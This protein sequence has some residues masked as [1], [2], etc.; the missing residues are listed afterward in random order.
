[1]RSGTRVSVW[2]DRV[3]SDV[4]TCRGVRGKF[5]AGDFPENPRC[6]LSFVGAGDLSPRRR[7]PPADM[8]SWTASARCALVA[9]A[10]TARGRLGAE[11]RLIHP[12]RRSSADVR[13]RN[14]SG[15]IVGTGTRKRSARISRRNASRLIAHSSSFRP[16]ESSSAPVV[17]WFRVGDLRT[18]DHPGLTRAFEANAPVVPVFVFDEKELRDFTPATARATHEAVCDLREALRERG[19]ELVVRTGDPAEIVPRLI[20]ETKARSVSVQVELEWARRSAYADALKA[21]SQ[22]SSDVEINEW[23]LE[24]R[25]DTDV[26]A[27]KERAVLQ[28]VLSEGENV[29]GAPLTAFASADARAAFRGPI[30]TPKTAPAFFPAGGVVGYSAVSEHGE[31]D[32]DDSSVASDATEDSPVPSLASVVAMARVSDDP[33]DVAHDAAEAAFEAIVSDASY[34]KKK[35]STGSEN[36]FV[37]FKGEDAVKARAL[38][39]AA[40]ATPSVPFRL[41]GGE[42]AALRFLDGFLDFYTATNDTEYK[43]MYA[44]IIEVG[45]PEA[46]FNVFGDALRVGALSP[47]VVYRRCNEWEARSKRATDL[48]ANA[49]NVANARDYQASV[50]ADALKAG[51]YGPGVPLVGAYNVCSG[52]L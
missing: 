24:L 3:R 45:K 29:K 41:P 47:R 8:A 18:H 5:F 37:L 4:V 19:L 31:D 1:M 2:G 10:A 17:V 20:Q 12:V 52:K 28:T 40:R 27:E 46:F 39:E 30:E 25:G 11:P 42:H 48:C 14:A 21:V 22:K 51:T 35:K 15:K 6:Q 43:R 32:E 26:A 34:R 7:R 13:F 49:R 38:E 16:A 50:A 44:R 36:A 33:F 23:S 9:P